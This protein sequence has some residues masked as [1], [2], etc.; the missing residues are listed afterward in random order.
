MNG[1]EKILVRIEEDAQAEANR[2]LSEAQRETD[3]IT[4][5]YTA[6]AEHLRTVAQQRAQ[7]AAK[8]RQERLYSAAQMEAKKQT[9]TEKQA[10]LD[11]AFLQ[12]E[13]LLCAL[14]PQAYTDLLAK[15][16]AD[17]SRT[18]SELITLSAQDR[19]AIG[20]AVVA[21]ANDLLNKAGRNAALA[22]SEETAPISGG[23]LLG[24]GIIEVNCSFDTLLRLCRD[25]SA[26]EVAAILFP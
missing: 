17:V 20:P 10:M 21:A 3:S 5:R 6:Q 13:K 19:D 23:L 8:E 26:V 15:F 4:S 16:A 11:R 18:G 24:D 9:L 25:K 2:I 12:A 14:P 1:I 22:L 7:E